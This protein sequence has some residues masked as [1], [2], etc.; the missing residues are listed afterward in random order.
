MNSFPRQPSA[1]KLRE[2][3]YDLQLQFAHI[4]VDAAEWEFSLRYD[5]HLKAYMMQ[6]ARM[7]AEVDHDETTD[8]VDTFLKEEKVYYSV[9]APGVWNAIK[10]YW[11]EPFR[12]RWGLTAPL[13]EPKF[14]SKSISH[15]FEG[16]IVYHVTRTTRKVVAPPG[17]R[18]YR[19][20]KR[21]TINDFRLGT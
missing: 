16:E 3:E 10:A 4:L 2:M 12:N 1:E 20:P 6:L 18:T 7:V 11:L 13:F 17:T 19:E 5:D 8:S 15:I 21:R 14:V 9:L